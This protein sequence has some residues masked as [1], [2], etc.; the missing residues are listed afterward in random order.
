MTQRHPRW[1]ERAQY[2][3]AILMFALHMSGFDLRSERVLTVLLVGLYIG[4]AL[5]EG[6]RAI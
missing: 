3:V 5:V 4:G 1:L 2:V 6:L